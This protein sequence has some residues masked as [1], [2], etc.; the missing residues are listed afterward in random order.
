MWRDP[1]A[2]VLELVG[3][4]QVPG[5]G[6]QRGVVNID[7]DADFALF[8]V[9][10]VATSPDLTIALTDQADRLL[11]DGEQHAMQ[12]AGTGQWQYEFD[13]GRVIKRQNQLRFVVR[14]LSGAPN[15]VRILLPGAQLYPGPPYEIP[16]WRWGE[17]WI[18]GIRF[19]PSLGDDRP[20]VP[21][22]GAVEFALRLPGDSWFEIHRLTM[23]VTG[24]CTLQLLT[25]AVREWFRLPV[26]STLLGA[27][28]FTG[29]FEGVASRRPAA[30][31]YHF[32]PP[33]LLPPNTV[34]VAR[35]AD[36]SG[37]PN[38][39]RIALHGVRRYT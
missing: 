29:T 22:N 18:A 27:S 21:A 1:Y 38:T 11:W 19:G 12:V 8:R 33:K 4:S 26:H 10:L 31:P 34:V 17:P 3:A 15:D 35:V 20:A 24:A 13:A 16:T 39:V 9:A 30:W 25:N 37:A 32:S 28:S 7:R 23:A 6:Q 2:Y 5:G 36:L 14:D